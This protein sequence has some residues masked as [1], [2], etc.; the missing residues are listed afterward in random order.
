M[1]AI[2]STVYHVFN[3]EKQRIDMAYLDM[4]DLIMCNVRSNFSNP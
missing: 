2:C 1:N 3:V 4:D